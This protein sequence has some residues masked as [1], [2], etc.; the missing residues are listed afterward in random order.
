MDV[1]HSKREKRYYALGHT[2]ADRR[3]FVVFTIRGTLI[4]V[5]SVREMNRRE[6]DLYAKH[7]KEADS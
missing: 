2:S 5:I 4:R 1:R 7:E 3:L 6:S